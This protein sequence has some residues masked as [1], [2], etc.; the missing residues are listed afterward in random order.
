MKYLLSLGI[1]L[2]SVPL[3]ASEIILE[4]VTLRRGMEGDTR[5]S[6]ALDDPKTYSKNKVYR[7]EKELAAQAGVEI[8]QFLDDYYAKGFRKESGANK[9]VH[10]LLFYNSISAPQCKREYLIQRIR[11]TN[12]Y[13]QEN[14]KISSKAV[15]YLVEVFKLN[16]Y[17]HTKRADGH[18]QLHF[19]GDV[20]SRKTVVDIEVG[21]GEVRGV[22]D[23][24]AWPFQQ[25]ILF[26]ELQDYSN[27]PGLYDKVSFEFSRSYSFT[28][29]FD[30]NG[31]KITLPDFLR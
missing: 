27:K 30:R 28:S 25:K 19:L 3:S 31:H 16:S 26:K 23:G 9:A 4:Q 21:C 22:A 1:V 10:Y 29:E 7:E 12:T 2:F 24:L 5:Q 11:Q 8:D 14:R 13:Y 18:V 6:G 15:E 20:Q 17:G